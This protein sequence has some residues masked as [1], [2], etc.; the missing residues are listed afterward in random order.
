[1]AG[2]PV[3]W[4]VGSAVLLLALAAPALGMKLGNADAGNE[5]EST[6]IRKAYD[7][8][9][10]GFGPGANAPLLVA[11]DVDDASAV[12]PASRRWPTDLAATPGVAAVT[13]AQLSPDGAAA[14][15]TVTPDARPAGRRDHRAARPHPRR[16]AAGRRARR[17]HAAA[18]TDF[19]DRLVGEP[20]MIVAV[21][22]A[23]RSC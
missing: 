22:L 12:R 18:M 13:P 8:V 6:T 14:V 20:W 10:D 7:L 19:T 16:A 4:L 21:V 11:M 15:L 23:R 5:P 9:A 17:L 2:R 3:V 1:M